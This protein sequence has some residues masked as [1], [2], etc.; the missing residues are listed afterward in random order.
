MEGLFKMKGRFKSLRPYADNIMDDYLNND[1]NMSEISEK[2]SVHYSNL[3]RFIKHE[4]KER[5][6]E[7]NF[8]VQYLNVADF[9]YLDIGDTFQF[10]ERMTTWKLVKITEKENEL[11]FEMVP[12]NERNKQRHWINDE[13]VVSDEAR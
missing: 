13:L 3:R 9:K 8:N 1:M 7:E 12:A 5:G 10:D 11:V 4:I 6:L 2:Y